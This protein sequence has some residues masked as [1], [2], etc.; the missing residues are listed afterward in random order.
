[1]NEVANE[2]MNDLY[3]FGKSIKKMSEEEQVKSLLDYLDKNDLTVSKA[4]LLLT[5]YSS[6]NKLEFTQFS[7]GCF[8]NLFAGFALGAFLG[9]K[10]VVTGLIVACV[11][12]TLA[13]LDTAK[14]MRA[15]NVSQLRLILD[16]IEYEHLLKKE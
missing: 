2:V 9:V 4:K 14:R 16:T 11:A 8:A 13:G 5:V 15:R 12:C 6:V 7:Y 3:A 10:H 1:M